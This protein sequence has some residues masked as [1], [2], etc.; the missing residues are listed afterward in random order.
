MEAL[1]KPPAPRFVVVQQGTEEEAELVEQQDDVGGRQCPQDLLHKGQDLVSDA[2][3]ET[4]LCLLLGLDA[5]VGGWPGRKL[6][7]AAER[8]RHGVV[9][10]GDPQD[11]VEEA[12]R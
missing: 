9:L 4:G 2:L 3:G 10:H 7:Q 8:G 6:G 11:C 1:Q 5:K 12:V